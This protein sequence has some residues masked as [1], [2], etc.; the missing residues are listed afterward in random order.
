M[1]TSIIASVLIAVIPDWAGESAPFDSVE[2]L[3]P[4]VTRIHVKDTPSYDRL[5]W[6]LINHSQIDVSGRWAE[7]AS[8]L[9]SCA[10]FNVGRQDTLR[11]SW[12]FTLRDRKLLDS[13]HILLSAQAS[14][15]V[16]TGL[17]IALPEPIFGGEPKSGDAILTPPFPNPFCGGPTYHIWLG[18]AGRATVTLASIEGKVLETILDMSLSEG[19]HRLP[20]PYA[21]C[22]GSGVY[23]LRLQVDGQEKG[24]VQAVLL[25]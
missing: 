16:S 4:T 8:K 21:E 15:I 25:R 11:F 19:N 17:T 18:G 10:K 23:L 1:L 6:G 12:C 20:I 24:W 9:S 22:M 3:E 13:L 14:L 5:E 2:I 7:S